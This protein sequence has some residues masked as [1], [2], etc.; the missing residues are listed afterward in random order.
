MIKI[1]EIDKTIAGVSV[2]IAN[3]VF[4]PG[5]VGTEK[6]FGPELFKSAGEFES[7]LVSLGVVN[8]TTKT[9]KMVKQLLNLGLYVLFE[10]IDDADTLE[11]SAFWDKLKDKYKYD[12]KFICS[13]CDTDDGNLAFAS[14]MIGVATSRGDCFALIDHAKSIVPSE[15]KTYA[16][17]V[18]DTLAPFAT[19]TGKFAAAFSPWGQFTIGGENIELPGSFAYLSA[20]ASS[21]STYPVWFAVAG[22]KRG[23]IPGFV[24]PLYEYGQKD[25]ELLGSRDMVET[26]G[27]WEFG[28]N[29]NEGFAVNPICNIN[30]YGYIIWGNRTL[31][32]NSGLTAYSFLNIRNIVCEIKKNLFNSANKYMFEQN[33]DILWINFQSN[34]APVLERM[35]AGSGIVDYKLTKES[36][37]RKGTLKATI[38][39]IP[40]E[41]VEDFDLTVELNDSIEVEE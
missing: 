11:T 10:G 26:S 8:A 31:V 5:V 25:V 3:T 12:F 27:N 18:H 36:T 33:N 34:V 38:K 13:G 7:K 20:L 22:S 6:T 37:N 14:D 1:N 32:M 35:K 17:E 23:V 9:I 2:G 28:S 16:E 39:I 15:D 21:L 24:K 19:A 4:V 30:P 41:A 29:D 40:I